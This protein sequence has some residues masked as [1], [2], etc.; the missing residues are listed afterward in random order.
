MVLVLKAQERLPRTWDDGRGAAVE[1]VGQ[2]QD[3]ADHGLLIVAVDRE[4]IAIDALR[5]PG[6]VEQPIPLG[7]GEGTWDALS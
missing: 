2:R 4:H 1:L 7:L 6:L 3:E 5:F